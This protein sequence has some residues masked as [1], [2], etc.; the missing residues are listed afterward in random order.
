M[1]VVVAVVVV[2]GKV[3]T[4]KL[5]RVVRGGVAFSW[6]TAMCTHRWVEV[7]EVAWKRRRRRRCM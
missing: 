7:W 3:A 4:E 1:V 6:E 5:V 2:V